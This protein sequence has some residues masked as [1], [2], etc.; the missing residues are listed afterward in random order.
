MPEETDLLSPA[1]GIR[2][3]SRPEPRA[4]LSPDPAVGTRSNTNLSKLVS[5]FDKN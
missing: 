4:V 1:L 5:S 2:Y 3:R